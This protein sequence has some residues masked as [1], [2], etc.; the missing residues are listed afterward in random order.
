MKK[1][2]LSLI[3]LLGIGTYAL[4][5]GFSVADV[6][7]RSGKSGVLELVFNTSFYGRSF[8]LDFDLPEG[9]EA[10][11]VQK[12]EAV[13]AGDGKYMLDG[14]VTEG[15]YRVAYTDFDGS[16]LENGVAAYITLNDT[17]GYEPGTELTVTVK[18]QEYLYQETAEAGSR[19][20][21]ANPDDFTFKIKIVE[22]VI[23]FDEAATTLPS[24]STGE[25]GNVRVIRTMKANQWSTVVLPFTITNANLK[26]A[27][28]DDAQYAYFSGWSA[29]YDFDNEDY[30]P[31]S[32]E[33]NFKTK[34][35]TPNVP[36]G[37]AFLVKPSKDVESFEFNQVTLTNVIDDNNSVDKHKNT[38]S[39]ADGY[40]LTGVF[41][42]TF[43]ATKVPA[44]GLYIS[45]E[46]FYYS[47]GETNIK[48]FR[49]WFELGAVLDKDTDFGVKMNIY[50]DGEETA[51]DDVR[52]VD[53]KGAVY[54]IDGKFIGR[55]V[56][57]KKLQKGIYVIDGKKVAIK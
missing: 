20:I 44:D 53:T 37:I 9:I 13:T 29:V 48:G 19:L 27:F 42:S 52:F 18:K 1:F 45:G 40:G 23:I 41:K 57:V 49:G 6:E 10:S 31:K 39:D 50:V 56:D 14:N 11:V 17:Q 22:D 30:T 43:V 16:I 24:F 5:D 7:I 55:N 8:Q 54:T 12:G 28:G 15:I 35:V 38:R 46:K 21:K 34:G 36:G 3:A 26:A 51:I 33:V 25:K 32:I 47:T 4:A 2:L